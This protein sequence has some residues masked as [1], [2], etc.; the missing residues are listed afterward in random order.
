M[1]IPA[2]IPNEKGTT[3]WTTVDL[4]FLRVNGKRQTT[5]KQDAT[6]WALNQTG[7]GDRFGEEAEFFEHVSAIEERSTL[8]EA[9]STAVL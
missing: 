1:K 6:D 4:P 9:A 7:E 8:V 5:A 3:F 2:I